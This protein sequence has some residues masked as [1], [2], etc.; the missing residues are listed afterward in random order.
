MA[1]Y[2]MQK[3][4]TSKRVVVHPVGS[5]CKI[6]LCFL[7]H[8]SLS[9][10]HAYW[11]TMVGVIARKGEMMYTSTSFPCYSANMPAL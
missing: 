1:K 10:L 6:T 5:L 11:A 2:Y 7:G 8:I 4:N 3:A 9:I